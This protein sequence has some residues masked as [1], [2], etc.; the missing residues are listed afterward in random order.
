MSAYKNPSPTT[1][2]LIYEPERGLV[3][4]ERS[5]EPHGFALPG[6]FIDYGE[7][8]EHAAI[9]EMREETSLDVE[10][11]GI[12]GVYSEPTR[13]IRFHTMSIAF[14]AKAKNPDLLCAGDDAKNAAFFTLDSLPE[15]AFDH[16]KIIQ[17][18]ILY[19]QGKRAL[20]PLDIHGSKGI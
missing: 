16:H 18:F 7:S 11:C 1:D 17:D 9:R 12:L 2:V 14:V 13:D 15:L 4:I 19:L 10:L 5:N 6:G 3:L 20:V 8:A